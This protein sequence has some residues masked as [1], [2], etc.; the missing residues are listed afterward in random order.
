VVLDF[1]RASYRRDL[2]GK[3]C[4]HAIAS[5]LDEATLVS[6]QTR[7][8]DLTSDPSDLGIRG[9]LRSLHEGGITHDV[10]SQDNG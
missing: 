4:E 2:T 8:D 3:F 9:L 5:R 10:R 6:S 7:L 1:G